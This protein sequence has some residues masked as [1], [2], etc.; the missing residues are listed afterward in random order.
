MAEIK[1]RF[2]DPANP[3]AGAKALAR[4]ASDYRAEKTRKPAPPV[5]TVKPVSGFAWQTAQQ[6]EDDG[7]VADA[8]AGT[9]CQ[10]GH[11]EAYHTLRKGGGRGACR[12]D[13]DCMEFSEGGI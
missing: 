5:P 4:Y 3:S 1:R 7:F 12:Q 6:A 8:P 10:C 13:C 11:E 9:A 2:V